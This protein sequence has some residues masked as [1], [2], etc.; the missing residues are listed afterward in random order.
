MIYI[1][2]PSPDAQLSDMSIRIII[3]PGTDSQWSS[4]M[5]VFKHWDTFLSH[6][7]LYSTPWPTEYFYTNIIELWPWKVTFVFGMSDYFES[8]TIHATQDRLTMLHAHMVALTISRCDCVTTWLEKSFTSWN[9]PHLNF[10]PSVTGWH[11]PTSQ[12]K[13]EINIHL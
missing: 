11:L 6:C 3:F 9:L 12:I 1:S 13:S 7:M 8:L 10:P 2:D 4:Y 5:K